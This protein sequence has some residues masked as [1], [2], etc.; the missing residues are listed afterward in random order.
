MNDLRAN[1]GMHVSNVHSCNA[2]LLDHSNT[3][4]KT[5]RAIY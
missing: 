2:A 1:P 4:G 3:T 5:T